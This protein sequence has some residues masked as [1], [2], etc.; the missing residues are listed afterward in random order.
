M[1]EIKI[2]SIHQMNLAGMKLPVITIYDHPLDHPM[3]VIVRAWDTSVM[4]PAP[5]REYVSYQ[6]IPQ[7]EDDIRAAGFRICLP[8]NPAD[9]KCIVASYIK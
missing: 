1:E 2:E 9:A 7:A 8:R 5:T 4:P 6:T 3:E